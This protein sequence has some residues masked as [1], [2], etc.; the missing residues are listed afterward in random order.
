GGRKLSLGGK[1]NRGGTHAR[2]RG[3]PSRLRVSFGKPGFRGSG[4]CGGA[5][6]HRPFGG[7]DPRNGVE[8]RC[9]AADGKG[10]RARGAWLPWRGTGDRRPGLKGQRNRL[11]GKTE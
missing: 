1:D 8:G 5:D 2:R 10:G 7:L 11:T 9:Q 3:D 4:G 6:L